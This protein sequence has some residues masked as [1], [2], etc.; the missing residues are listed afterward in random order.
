M[1]RRDRTTPVQ[2]STSSVNLNKSGMCPS[3]PALVSEGPVSLLYPWRLHTHSH[4]HTHSGS[5]RPNY[6]LENAGTHEAPDRYREPTQGSLTQ[7]HAHSETK[8]ISCLCL[9]PSAL[10]TFQ[11]PTPHMD[12][13]RTDLSP[14]T[15]ALGPDLSPGPSQSGTV[16][17]SCG[18]RG[19]DD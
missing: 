16:Y 10:D 12:L 8:G 19:Q 7:L 1:L 15:E 18:K 14:I 17:C 5:V 13:L 2:L 6:L 3:R 4:T 9:N 11:L